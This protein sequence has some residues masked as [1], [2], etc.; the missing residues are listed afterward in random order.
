MITT[1]EHIRGWALA[2]ARLSAEHQRSLRSLLT[3]AHAASGE[4]ALSVPLHVGS[5]NIALAK[6][7]AEVPH[8][9]LTAVLTSIGISKTISVH[10][11]TVLPVDS[12]KIAS[13]ALGERVGG[14]VEVATHKFRYG[15]H[16]NEWV[17]V[18][19]RHCRHALGVLALLR[20]EPLSQVF[21]S[22]DVSKVVDT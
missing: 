9:L 16:P 17:R 18:L 11:Y 4:E 7:G 14:I 12:E 5:R 13:V 10:I 6:L 15:T 8:V 19:S 2:P 22:T 21:S 20:A 1:D 3:E